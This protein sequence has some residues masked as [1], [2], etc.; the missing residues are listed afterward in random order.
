MRAA[1]STVREICRFLDGSG[2]RTPRGNAHWTVKTV[3]W[4]LANRAYLE[5][6]RHGNFV[7]GSAHA[8]IIDA[9][10]FQEAQVS[11]ILRPVQS[12]QGMSLLGGLIRCASCVS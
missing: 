1:G 10:T 2:A 5:R 6:S 12:N 7:N 3:T 8:P 11:R 9:V 4:L